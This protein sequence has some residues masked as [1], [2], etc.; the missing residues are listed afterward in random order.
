MEDFE[1]IPL[2]KGDV[3]TVYLRDVATVKDGA[4]ITTGYALVDG[5]RSVYIN[6]MSLSGLALAVGILVDESTVT[7]ENIHQHLEMGKKNF[8]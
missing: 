2:Y 8:S 4:D 7:I 1:N 3:Q 6:I 5:K